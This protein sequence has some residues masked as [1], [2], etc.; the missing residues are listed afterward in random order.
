MTTLR[1]GFQHAVQKSR[2]TLGR[3]ECDLERDPVLRRLSLLVIDVT[4]VL[5]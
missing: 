3:Y 1:G 4:D 5:F 2:V